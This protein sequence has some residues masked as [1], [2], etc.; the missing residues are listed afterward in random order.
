MDTLKR[1][2]MEA[3]EHE[4]LLTWLFGALA[5]VATFVAAKMA[6]SIPKGWAWEYV[7]RAA[8]AVKLAVKAVHQ[9][10]VEE[11]KRG[12]L[13][14]SPGGAVLTDDEK[15]NAKRM[16][17][18]RAKAMLGGTK[19]LNTALWILKFKGGVD[20][21]LDAVLESTVHDT[22]GTPVVV[23]A[24]PPASAIAAGVSPSP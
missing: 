24:S 12:R 8:E 6:W 7:T 22:K 13:A 15:A 2:I 16:A 11:I 14:T 3:L 4:E 21:W 17:L 5:T 10:Y 9:T 20:P 1:L 18:D 23:A 19:L